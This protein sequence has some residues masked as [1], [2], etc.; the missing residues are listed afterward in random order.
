MY[1]SIL[2]RDLKRKKTMNVI[3]MLFM[4][5]AVMFVSS[6]VNTVM[7]V[8]SATDNYMDMS[9]AHDY[10]VATTGTKA[11]EDLQKKLDTSKAV[12]L[13]KT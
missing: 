3:L 6:S 2:K 5:L 8:M 7:S 10:F 13:Y 1:F 9:D 11:V 4:I 12:K